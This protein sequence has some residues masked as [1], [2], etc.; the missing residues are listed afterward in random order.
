MFSLG[1]K[2]VYPGH[3]VATITRIL[4]KAMGGELT[5]FYELTFVGKG[6]IILVPCNALNCGVRP[7]SS[8]ELIDSLFDTLSKPV[9]KLPVT[10][11]ANN[12]K[13]R[14]KE[15]QLRLRTG[16]IRDI[17][18]IYQELKHIEQQKELSFCEKNLLCHT[19]TMLAE[20]IALVKQLQEEKAAEQLRSCFK[21]YGTVL[22]GIR[23]L[24]IEHEQ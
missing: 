15:Y 3:G 11:L 2:V 1:D 23:R 13:Q 14:N 4:E 22:K 12:W 7:L 19:E 10:D 8:Q 16:N 18:A 9:K 5:L 17:S 6:M 21:R 24:P 20:E